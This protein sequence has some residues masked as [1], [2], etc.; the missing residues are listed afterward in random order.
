MSFVFDVP[1]GCL[2]VL[3]VT[4]EYYHRKHPIGNTSLNIGG[5]CYAELVAEEHEEGSK[6]LWAAHELYFEVAGG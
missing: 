1:K 2:A 3:S 5:I 6:F 4:M